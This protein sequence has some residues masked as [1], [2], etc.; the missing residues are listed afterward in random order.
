MFNS[1]LG[2]GGKTRKTQKMH[3]CKKKYQKEKTYGGLV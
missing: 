2:A 1:G 3:Y